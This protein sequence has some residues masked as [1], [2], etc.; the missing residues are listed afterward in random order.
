M[1]HKS[2][3]LGPVNLLPL[4][5]GARDLLKQ[6]IVFQSYT[7]PTSPF[8]FEAVRTDFFFVTSKTSFKTF[9]TFQSYSSR[10]NSNRKDFRCR[11]KYRKVARSFVKKLH[12]YSNLPFEYIVT[13]YEWGGVLTPVLKEALEA[14]VSKFAT[15][16]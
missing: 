2:Y 16:K 5:P 12:G 9:V 10:E 11:P 8:N 4:H 15:C 7:E 13:L 14:A 3:E 6:R 1:L